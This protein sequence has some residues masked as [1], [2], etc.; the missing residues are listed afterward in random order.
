MSLN[1][2]GELGA[3][4]TERSLLLRI[5]PNEDP[6]EIAKRYTARAVHRLGELMEETGR[7]SMVAVV[8]CQTLIKLAHPDM[9]DPRVMKLVEEKFKALVDEARKRLEARQAGAIDA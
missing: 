7:Q 4:G 1:P 5:D 2:S 6:R 9:D 3:G 8:A